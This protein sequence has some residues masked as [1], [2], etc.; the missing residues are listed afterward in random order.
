MID[1]QGE[2][3]K[4]YTD[5]HNELTLETISFGLSREEKNLHVIK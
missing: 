5:T 1:A 4:K 2:A 3:E